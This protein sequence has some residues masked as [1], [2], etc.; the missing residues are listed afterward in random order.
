MPKP[1]LYE[2]LN[3][4]IGGVHENLIIHLPPYMPYETSGDGEAASARAGESYHYHHHHCYH[5]AIS[6]G[7]SRRIFAVKR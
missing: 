1:P 3:I 4:K 5:A 7:Y 2:T 6:T